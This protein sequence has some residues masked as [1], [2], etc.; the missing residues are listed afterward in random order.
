MNRIAS[1]ILAS[2]AALLV[3]APSQ[4]LAAT[5]PANRTA[6]A[7]ILHPLTL[8]KLEDMEF[9]GLIVTSAGTA[10]INPVTNTLS[11]TGG[12]IKVSGTP[13]AARFRGSAAGGPVVNLKVPNQP[14]TLKRVG[15]TETITL[16]NFTLD[17]PT[18]R[19]MGQ[20]PS[21][22]FRVGGTLTIGAN[23]AEGDYVGTFTVTAQYP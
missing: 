3:A 4:L 13:H 15:G 9:S 16:S 8:Q 20:A 17:G 6:R 14:V 1:C 10:V 2:V 22:D 7:F 11:T 19:A 12:V 21:F 23:Q 18:K 5:P